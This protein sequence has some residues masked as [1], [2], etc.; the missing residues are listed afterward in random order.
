M[1]DISPFRRLIEEIEAE[2]RAYEA[3][4]MDAFGPRLR[5]LRKQRG[6][7]QVEFSQWLGTSRGSVQNW[8]AKTQRPGFPTVVWIAERLG[9]SLD[10]LAGLSDD[11]RPPSATQ[12]AAEPLLDAQRAAEVTP[13]PRPR[14]T[15]REQSRKGAD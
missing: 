15:R 8:E 4:V 3:G 7:K 6:E 12:R 5:E 10:Y 9:V 11:P 14:R 1:D 13:P 2:C